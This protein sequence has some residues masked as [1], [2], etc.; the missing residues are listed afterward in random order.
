MEKALVVVQARF[1]SRRLPGKALMPIGGEPLIAYLLRRL[2]T[3]PGGYRIVLAT[4]TNSGDD[5]L[6]KA[7]LGIGV[8]VVRGEEDDVLKRYMR[9]LNVFPSAIVVRVTADNPLV[10]IQLITEAVRKLDLGGYDYVR[11]VDGYAPGVGVDVFSGRLLEALD[12][13]A[14]DAY[15]REHIDAYVLKHKKEFRVADIPAPPELSH[16]EVR[17][18][19]DTKEDYDKV[20][21]VV[22]A[23]PSGGFIRSSDAVKY[24]IKRD[25][26]RK[27]SA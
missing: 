8:D 12:K 17:L 11:A 25:I 6:E 21:A 22:E 14:L 23:F 2:K 18:T 3:L 1:N 5:A 20:K 15:E 10:D 26:Q 16:T 9:C 19:V 24:V 13:K 27:V 7:A 4:T